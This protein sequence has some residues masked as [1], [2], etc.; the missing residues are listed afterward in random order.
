MKRVPL[1]A[2][3]LFNNVVQPKLDNEE[4]VDMSSYFADWAPKRLKL[5]KKAFHDTTYEALRVE[6]RDIS[7]SYNGLN[8]QALVELRTKDNCV[9]VMLKV[10][11]PPDGKVCQVGS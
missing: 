1:K 8:L 7:M 11:T 5:I 3:K 10:S 6:A 9:R 2:S 4:F